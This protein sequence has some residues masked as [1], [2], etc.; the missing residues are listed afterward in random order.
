[1]AAVTD[2]SRNVGELYVIDR[3]TVT[4]VIGIE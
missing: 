2:G 3:W 1:L 4:P